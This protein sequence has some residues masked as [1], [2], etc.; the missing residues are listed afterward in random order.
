M[1]LTYTID[2]MFCYTRMITLQTTFYNTMKRKEFQ[3]K[4]KTSIRMVA[5]ISRPCAVG[6]RPYHIDHS[7]NMFFLQKNVSLKF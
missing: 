1:R 4:N 7:L 3:K 6:Q 5:M 2:I